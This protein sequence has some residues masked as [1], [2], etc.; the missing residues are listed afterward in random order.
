MVKS[1]LV[2]TEAIALATNKPLLGT[3]PHHRCRVWYW[4]GED[5]MDELDRRIAAICK[6]H[7]ITA[8][9]LNGWLFVNGRDTEIVI[10]TQTRD[11]AQIAKPVV[12]ALIDTIEDH[13]IDVVTID[14]F[15]AAHQ[16]SENDNCAIDRV[17][18]QWTAIAD[19]TESAI[20]LVHHSRKTGGQE[21]TVEHGRGAVA[22]INACRSARVL[23]VM[24]KEEGAKAGVTAHRAYFRVESGKANLA[25]PPEAATWHHIRS[26][27][28]G[29]GHGGGLLDQGDNVGVIEPW[30]WPDMLEGV[31]GADFDKA[32][33]EIR[34][35][36]WRKH[37]EA[38]D[39]VGK[40]VAKALGF[41]L[42]KVTDKAR[43]LGIVKTW[44]AAGSLEVYEDKTKER[45]TK[46]FVRVSEEV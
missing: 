34:K 14:P 42:E 5:P 11:G 17:A 27:F 43:V 16:V 26:V 9:D 7:D 39:W 36:K 19:E 8:D 6:H 13:R 3:T 41:N 25:P 37:P 10:A 31:T 24:T 15:I 44:L 46:E 33:A 18:K 2:L 29:N 1:S 30:S 22:L 35:G 12:D 20:E 21:V 23:N 32:A 28:L 45:Q 4:N 38:K 40:P